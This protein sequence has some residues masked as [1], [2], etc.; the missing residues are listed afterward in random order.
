MRSTRLKYTILLFLVLVSIIF[1]ACSSLASDPVTPDITIPSTLQVTVSVVEDQDASDG[2]NGMSVITLGFST[3]EV[4]PPETAI[5]INEESVSCKNNNKTNSLPL[6]NATSYWFRVNIPYN[7]WYTCYYQYFLKGQH[8]I[9]TIF[10]FQA[11]PMPLSPVFLRPVGNNSNFK[12]RYNPGNPNPNVNECTVQV[13][14][15]APNG[16]VTGIKTSQNG[17]TYLGEADV[18]TLNGL[19]NIMMTRTCTPINFNHDN[20]ADDT[21]LEFAAVSVTYTSTASFEV[22]WYPPSSPTQGTNS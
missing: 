4:I 1:Y 8:K 18:G 15:N 12:V 20:D 5:F 3:N 22:S 2:Q 9:A 10:S 16:N 21:G 13:T 11:P 19:G 6:G 17:N 14:A 7:S